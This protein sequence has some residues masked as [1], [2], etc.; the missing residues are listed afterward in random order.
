[1]YCTWFFFLHS[2]LSVMSTIENLRHFCLFILR[3]ERFFYLYYFCC[4]F[5]VL[6]SFIGCCCI[7]IRN[8]RRWKKFQ[9]CLNA[10]FH[11]FNGAGKVQYLHNFVCCYVRDAIIHVTLMGV[12][13]IANIDKEKEKYFCTKWRIKRPTNEKNNK[14]R[15]IYSEINAHNICWS[16]GFIQL[17]TAR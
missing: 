15:R 2:C 12:T 7:G 1:M 9:H 8:R 6:Y 11:L 3:Y 13:A 5:G 14:R 17:A 4:G 10:F 16:M